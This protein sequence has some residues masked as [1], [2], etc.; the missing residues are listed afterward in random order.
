[1]TGAPPNTSWHHK[2]RPPTGVKCQDNSPVRRPHQ[3]V[4]PSKLQNRCPYWRTCWSRVT[5]R[6]SWSGT[7]TGNCK[8]SQNQ[9]TR[10]AADGLWLHCRLPLVEHRSIR[11]PNS[12]IASHDREHSQK[13][14]CHRCLFARAGAAGF[15]TGAAAGRIRT[16]NWRRARRP[17]CRQHHKPPHQRNDDHQTGQ[18]QR[19]N[20]LHPASREKW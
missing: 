17:R 9:R 11:A 5:R 14:T 15:A 13:P 3:N 12:P 8:I 18:K 2:H 4:P 6:G 16:G 20:L 10:A 19:T 7:T 1:M